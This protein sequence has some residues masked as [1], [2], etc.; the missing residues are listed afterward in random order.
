M[1]HLSENWALK[2]VVLNPCGSFLVRVWICSLFT[3]VMQELWE[4][5]E[6]YI[7]YL[8]VPMLRPIG[9]ITICLTA[10]CSWGQLVSL[11]LQP[12]NKQLPWQKCRTWTFSV[13]F[14]SAHKK[15]ELHGGVNHAL[16]KYP[17]SIIFFVLIVVISAV[18]ISKPVSLCL[19]KTLIK[20]ESW[21]YICRN[22]KRQFN[23][24]WNS[25]EVSP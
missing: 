13:A 6:R 9:V 14:Y 25:D 1:V 5:T 21:Q 8:F 23:L 15:E 2:I 10:P 24:L 17:I 11:T 19:Q 16:F 18:P 12:R 3:V 4:R 20:N 7:L 22:P